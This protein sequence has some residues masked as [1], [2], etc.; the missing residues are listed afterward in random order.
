MNFELGISCKLAPAGETQNNGN[1]K[2]LIPVPE[3]GLKGGRLGSGDILDKIT[4]ITE[5]R[6]NKVVTAYPSKD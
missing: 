1:D 2:Y 4:I 6:T 3:S 5:G